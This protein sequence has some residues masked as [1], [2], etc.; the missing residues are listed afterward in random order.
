MKPSVYI[1]TT[2]PSYLSAWRSPELVMAANQESTRKWWEESRP[3]F[4]LFISEF[5]IYE[6]SA[7]DPKAAKRRLEIIA[8]LPELD[9]N[10][11]VEELAN[12]LVRHAAIPNKAKI[13]ALH[14]SVAAIHGVDYLLTWNCRHIAN[15]VLRPKI[16]AV[17]RAM[18]YEPPI[19]CTPPELTED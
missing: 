2:I 8:D 14:I 9:V 11:E 3:N 6:A 5:V 1:E 17:C 4:E 16:E 15:A 10:E 13:D 19:I 18:S 7:G 12:Q